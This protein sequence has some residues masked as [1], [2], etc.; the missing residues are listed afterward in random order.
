MSGNLVEAVRENREAIKQLVQGLEVP[1]PPI[2]KSNFFGKGIMHPP[3]TK[4]RA[5]IITNMFK[6]PIDPAPP[7][8]PLPSSGYVM[9]RD[10]YSKSDTKPEPDLVMSNGG[11]GKRKS[12]RRRPT[13][14]RRTTIRRPIKRRRTTKRRPTKRRR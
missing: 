7:S 8:P 3:L 14:R 4:D 12:K 6:T 13:K 10:P 9:G 2:R 1:P 5:N 11:S